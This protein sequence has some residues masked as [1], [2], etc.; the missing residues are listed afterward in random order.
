MVAGNLWPYK[1]CVYFFI[2]FISAIYKSLVIFDIQ[3]YKKNNSHF[4]CIADVYYT[5]LV[6]TADKNYS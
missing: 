4:V 6:F 1:F 3:L 2:S 5:H